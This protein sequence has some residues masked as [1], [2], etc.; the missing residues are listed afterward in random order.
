VQP[1]D[2]VELRGIDDGNGHAI[3]DVILRQ[4]PALPTQIQLL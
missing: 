3:L 1:T 4:I 2:A